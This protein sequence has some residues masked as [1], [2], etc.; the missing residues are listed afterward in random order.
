[1]REDKQLVAMNMRKDLVK[2]LKAEA[3]AMDLT[4]S[5]YIRLIISK[6]HK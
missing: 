6:R 1:M 4:F 5:A 2:Q 3:R